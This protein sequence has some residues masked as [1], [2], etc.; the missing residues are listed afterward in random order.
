[1]IPSDCG[2]VTKLAAGNICCFYT[3]S[4]QRTWLLRTAVDTWNCF[5]DEFLQLWGGSGPRGDAFPSSLFSG[6]VLKVLQS[7]QGPVAT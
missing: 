7:L 4:D 1:M 5:S 2:L 3:R 6:Q